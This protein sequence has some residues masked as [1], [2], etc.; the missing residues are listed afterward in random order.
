MKRAIL[1]ALLL[2]LASPAFAGKSENP[3]KGPPWQRSLLAAQ[4]QALKEGKPIFLYFTKT[5]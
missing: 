5:Y 3:P 2:A 4:E 1:C